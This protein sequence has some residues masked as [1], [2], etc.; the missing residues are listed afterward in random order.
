MFDRKAPSQVL[1]RWTR[2]SGRLSGRAC[3]ERDLSQP[4]KSFFAFSICSTLTRE[5]EKAKCF[6]N[7]SWPANIKW[8]WIEL[9]V[10]S[11]LFWL[12]NQ[13]LVWFCFVKRYRRR[14]RIRAIRVLF[15]N[16]TS[17]W[18]DGL[19]GSEE[20]S[21]SAPTRRWISNSKNRH[22]AKE[23]SQS[24]WELFGFHSFDVCAGFC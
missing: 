2:K 3:F 11:E 4:R 15:Q 17:A 6:D 10:E 9:N 20:S 24:H 8:S 19:I 21:T 18:V 1:I 13:S 14:T 5:F 7:A 23:S 12:L 22:K 16:V